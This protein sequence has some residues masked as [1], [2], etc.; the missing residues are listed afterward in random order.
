MHVE[1]YTKEKCPFCH[2]AKM[3]LKDWNIQFVEHQLGVDFTREML[4]EKFSTAKTYPVIVVDGFF[5]GGFEELNK[6]INESTENG[7]ML[8]NERSE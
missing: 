7:S 6:M 1:I 4:L 8:L 2:R 5:I 3:L